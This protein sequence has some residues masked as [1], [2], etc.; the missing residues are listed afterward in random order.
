MALALIL[1]A[2][3]FLAVVGVHQYG[4]GYEAGYRDGFNDCKQSQS[5]SG[6]GDYLRQR[7][8]RVSAEEDR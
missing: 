3:V 4:A 8:E 5:Y 1:L 6:Y 2:V 7:V